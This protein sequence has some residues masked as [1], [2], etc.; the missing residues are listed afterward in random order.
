M[1]QPLNVN[2]KFSSTDNVWM[3]RSFVGSSNIKK[4]GFFN[5]RQ[6]RWSLLFSPPESLPI[7]VFNMMLGNRNCSNS[8]EADSSVPSWVL[9]WVPIWVT[10]S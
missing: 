3:S 8:F 1:I 10:C 6:T 4:F 9:I 7:F 5:N 2:R